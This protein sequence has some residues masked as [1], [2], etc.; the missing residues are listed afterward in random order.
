MEAPLADRNFEKSDAKGSIQDSC[1]VHSTALND[2]FLMVDD[3]IISNSEDILKHITS[4]YDSLSTNM[5]KEAQTFYNHSKPHIATQ[6]L[7]KGN[8]HDFQSVESDTPPTTQ[9]SL[10]HNTQHSN[11]TRGS[12]KDTQ[13]QVQTR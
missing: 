12:R 1:S 9:E 7:I 11:N 13:R 2:D 5:D 4:F 8:L 6:A 3:N 10:P